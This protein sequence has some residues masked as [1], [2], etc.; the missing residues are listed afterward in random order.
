MKANQSKIGFRFQRQVWICLVGGMLLTPLSAFS[1]D[2]TER[3]PGIVDRPARDFIPE[4]VEEREGKTVELPESPA[5]RE[6][7]VADPGRVVIDNLTEVAFSG[8]EVM[9]ASILQTAVA[10]YLN[11]SVT[12][13]GLAE[14]KYALTKL[15]YDEGYVLVKVTTPPQD[16][17]DGVLDI[18]IYEAQ[19]GSIDIVDNDAISP[20]LLEQV[21]KRVKTGDTF[22]EGPVE[23]MVNDV[24][25]LGGVAATVN[26]SPGTEVGTT[27]MTVA[28]EPTNDDTQRFTIDNYA[29]ELTG[30][31][32]GAAQLQKSNLLGWGETFQ[33]NGR[34][35]LT[36]DLWSVAFGATVPV[37]YR[38]VYAHANFSYSENDIGGRLSGLDASSKS[39]G[40]S[41]ALSSALINR[42]S[43]RLNVRGGFTARRGESFLAGARE[44]TVDLRQLYGEVN[45]LWNWPNTVGFASLRLTQGIDVLGATDK[46]DPFANRLGADPQPTYVQ[47]LLYIGHRVMENGLL[48]AIFVGQYGSDKMMASDLISIGGYGTVRGFNPGQESGERGFFTNIEYQ[49]KLYQQDIWAVHAGP[50]LDAGYVDSGFENS[51]VDDTLVSAGIGLEVSTSP[52]LWRYGDS[53]MRFD[54]AHVIGDYESTI[55]DDSRFYF[56]FTQTF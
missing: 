40:A 27:D 4:E 56:R 36:E 18:V 12:A 48:K 11:Q 24:N 3:L 42:R 37:G 13:A 53:N 16:V 15:Y 6:E 14:M 1:V 54:W 55:H 43:E 9:D 34:K 31:W 22:Q 29:S 2:E 8:N 30:E 44:S 20:Y 41:F 47:P 45:Y 10:P 35:A 19:V 17:S 39:T 23:S 52:S 33:F 46:N 32:V 21:T 50:F 26:L 51:I 49:H 5:P 25:D 38:N 28:V 7:Q